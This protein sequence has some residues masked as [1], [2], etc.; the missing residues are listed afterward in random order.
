MDVIVN[1]HNHWDKL[2][3]V[4]VGVPY[5]LDYEI[6]ITFKLFFYL[7]I[8][9][10]TVGNN[11]KPS[12]KVRDESLEDL[13]EFINILKKENIIVKRPME[14][15]EVKITKSPWW[16]A[17][18]SHAMMSRDLFIIIGDQ[19]IETSPMVRSRYF[20]GDLYKQLFTEYFNGGAKWT[21]A[22]KSRLLEKNFDYS[23]VKARGFLEDI[24]NDLECEIMFDGAQIL[25]MGADLFFNCSTQNHRMGMDWLS[26]HLG[27]SYNVHE[28]NITDNHIDG[29]VLPL[30]PGTLLVS[31]LVDMDL[32][33]KELR[34][35]DIIWYDPVKISNEEEE[36][37]LLASA[38]IGM[39]VLSLDT[40]KVVV[41]DKQLYLIDSLKKN[42]FEPIPCKWRHGRILGG[43]FHCM[44]LDIRRQSKLESYL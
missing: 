22:P 29:K 38:N 30:R 25:R 39:N 24:P 11:Y 28:I 36:N 2:E 9:N 4:I 19:I 27:K 31:R 17:P 37:L 5:H 1:S 44:T 40:K 20:E 43:G 15:T 26:R 12:N 18:L 10:R 23:Y 41:Q 42:G 3:E 14:M 13:D 34:K 8:K 7:N 32:L 21:V 16:E 6:D 35:W 33:P